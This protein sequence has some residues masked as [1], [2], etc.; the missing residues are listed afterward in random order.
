MS[1]GKLSPQ[2]EGMVTHTLKCNLLSCLALPQHLKGLGVLAVL[3]LPAQQRK[4]QEHREHEEESQASC[5]GWQQCSPF[6]L[7]I[8]KPCSVLTLAPLFPTSPGRPR[9]PSGPGSPCEKGKDIPGQ[10]MLPVCMAVLH[11]A[12]LKPGV[13]WFE[14]VPGQCAL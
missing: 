4:T 1:V 5:P 6:L 9:V 10:G 11:D 14:T 12:L 2:K 13:S 7:D 8:T 3:V